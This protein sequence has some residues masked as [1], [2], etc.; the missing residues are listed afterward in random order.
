[1]RLWLIGVVVF[2]A[3]AAILVLEI[4]AGRIL[5]P[6]VGVTLQSFTAIIGTVLAGIAFGAWAGG[7]VADRFEPITERFEANLPAPVKEALETSRERV[8]TLLAV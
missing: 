5:A 8:R 6:Y 2:V 4:V 7:R 1:M 3:S